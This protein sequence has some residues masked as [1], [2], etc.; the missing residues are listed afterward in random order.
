MLIYAHARVVLK[1]KSLRLVQKFIKDKRTIIIKA[2]YD[3]MC[4]QIVDLTSLN[5]ILEA[6][7][8]NPLN[9][10]PSLPKVTD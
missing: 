5:D 6:T 1:S 2:F 9:W 4:H 7:R 8:I 3:K 10:T